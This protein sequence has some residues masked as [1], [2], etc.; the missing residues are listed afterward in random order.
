MPEIRKQVTQAVEV[1]Q[2]SMNQI[3]MKGVSNKIQKAVQLVKNKISSLKKSSQNNEIKIKVNNKEA[4]KQISQLEKEIDSLQKKIN[5]RQMKLDFINPQ[6]DKMVDDTRN[7][8]TPQGISKNDKSMDSVVNN[9][10]AS[11]KDFTSLNNQ[12]Q[13]LY[14]EIEAYNKQLS[15]AKSKMSQLKQETTQTATTQNKLSSFFSAF[16]ESLDQAKGSVSL[17]KKNF[18]Q[19]PKITQKITNNIKNMGTGL[20]SGLKHVLKYAAALFSL[21]GIY[22]VLSR[23][24]NSWLSS[25]NAGAQ[26]LSA[27]IEYMQYAMG[28]MFAP[29]IEYVINLVYQLLKAI[30]SLVYA[31][32]GINIFAKATAS[33]MNS[34]ASSANK[35]GKSLSGVHGE[36][37]NVSDNSNGGGSGSV[38]PSMDLSQMDTSM[39]S[40][41]EKIKSKLL[42]ICQPIKKSWD[43]Y[44]KSFIKSMNNAFDGMKRLI[45]SIG[46]SIN[47]VWTNGTGEKTISL[48]LQILTS[49][50]NVIGNIG[51]AF[52]NAWNQSG[53]GLM[54][55]QGLWNAFNNLLLIVSSIAE[56]VEKWTASESFQNFA[57]AI[58]GIIKVVVTLVESL[59]EKIKNIWDNAGKETFSKILEYLSKLY[60]AI[61][62]A[63]QFL[64]P[65]VEYLL[66]IV[67]PVIEGIIRF[68]GYI[69]DALSGVLDFIIGVFTGDWEKAWNGIKEFFIGI[70]NAIKTIVI[71]VINTIKTIISNALSAIKTVWSN[72]WNGIKV[73]VTNIWNGIWSVIKNIINNIL[74]WN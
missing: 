34:A 54:I 24:A 6:I 26:Q 9:A 32:S 19:M 29:V 43:T 69:I 15:E 2:K 16:K 62:M 27:N 71:T 67:V 66:N 11:N 37:N 53:I 28:S 44:G 33:S 18:N 41:I 50:F 22:S 51:E 65:V 7:E 61:G 40:W 49:V 14:T 47:E 73:V 13:K 58:I 68:L 20:K 25:Q 46:E 52:S 21:R 60:T 59:T 39:N 70:W 42:T 31:F 5:A 35:A 74:R 30:Q 48:I 23:A 3:D 8:V 10:L 12:A 64:A 56:T 36:I 38:T 17:L 55:I 57:N 4:E 63:I 45:N 72:V 1:A